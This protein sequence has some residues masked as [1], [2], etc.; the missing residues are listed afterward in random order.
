VRIAKKVRVKPED[1]DRG[2]KFPSIAKH[3]LKNDN[4]RKLSV[5]R[6]Q[7]DLRL[8]NIH[9]IR[10]VDELYFGHTIDSPITSLVALT[11][12]RQSARVIGMS[13]REK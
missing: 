12:P 8:L 9:A 13:V 4:E 3:L 2:D 5:E 11:A 6:K 10:N 7:H 1:A